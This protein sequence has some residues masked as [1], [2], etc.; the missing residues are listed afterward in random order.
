MPEGGTTAI[1]FWWRSQIHKLLT[2]HMGPYFLRE[3][4]RS[5]I[6][7]EVEVL[8][9]QVEPLNETE[10]DTDI[11][12]SCESGSEADE[13][14]SSSEP[15]EPSPGHVHDNL[16]E[17]EEQ[18]LPCNPD[19]AP[20]LGSIQH[21]HSAWEVLQLDVVEQ[22][23]LTW[24][25]SFLFSKA[26]RHHENDATFTDYN[27]THLLVK[28]LQTYSPP[29]ICRI[30]YTFSSAFPALM[31]LFWEIIP[32]LGVYMLTNSFELVEKTVGYGAA[33]VPQREEIFSRIYGQWEAMVGCGLVVQ[34]TTTVFLFIHSKTHVV[35]DCLLYQNIKM[36]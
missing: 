15:T 1:N 26:Q 25:A 3:V 8:M 32:P 35:Q 34:C 11:S 21:S 19:P 4:A 24:L 13:I 20:E 23:G 33:G 18:E 28:W 7:Q 36:Y 16:N 5:E 31:G 12:S 22:Q 27:S 10:L 9:A 6:K 14:D 30:L 17:L 29:T 2:G